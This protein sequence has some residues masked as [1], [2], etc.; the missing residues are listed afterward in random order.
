MAILN[1]DQAAKN[2]RW[3]I[4]IGG[5][6]ASVSRALYRAGLWLVYG[7]VAAEVIFH[8][9]MSE[10]RSA[11]CASGHSTAAARS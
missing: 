11:D 7:G 8:A 1:A 6:L 2:D 10:E 4:R 5:A 3:Q 9:A